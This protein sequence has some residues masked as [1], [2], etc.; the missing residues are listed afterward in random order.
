EKY[1]VLPGFTAQVPI[2]ADGTRGVWSVDLRQYEQYT[3]AMKT[4]TVGFPARKGNI[5]IY[6]IRLRAAE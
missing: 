6:G 1:P 3:G 4:F 2:A 5:K